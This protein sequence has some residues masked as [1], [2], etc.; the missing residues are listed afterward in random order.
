MS[1]FTYKLVRTG[2]QEAIEAFKRRFEMGKI[3][4]KV[5]LPDGVE[6]TD[7]NGK[8]TGAPLWKIGRAHEF[9]TLSVGGHIPER[10]W[11][12]GGIR[13]KLDDIRRLQKINLKAIANGKLEPLTALELLGQMAT[14]NIKMYIRSKPF[15]GLAE[16]TLAAR[17]HHLGKKTGS[18]TAD[19]TTPLIDQGNLIQAIT[20]EV[21]ERE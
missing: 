6:E 13:Y 20:Y 18:L 8:S 19:N 2:G 1:G 9:G 14:R 10:S 16:S 3:A 12:R 4:V 21:T 17:E 15:D 11:L 5:G 7:A